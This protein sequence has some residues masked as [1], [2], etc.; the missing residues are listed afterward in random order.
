M[1]FIWSSHEVQIKFEWS[2]TVRISR[3]VREKFIWISREIDMKL[4]WI[5]FEINMNCIRTKVIV[6]SFAIHMKWASRSIVG[7]ALWASTAAETCQTGCIHTVLTEYLEQTKVFPKLILI[8]H[9]PHHAAMHDTITQ[10]IQ[11]VVAKVG[12]DVSL[13]KPH[14]TRAASTSKAAFTNCL[15]GLYFTLPVGALN[16][17]SLVIMKNQ[18]PEITDCLLSNIQWVRV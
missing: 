6:I 15:C 1:K 4:I 8:M 17:H 11:N 5:S 13:F 12:V 18:S 3:S 16:A 2:L 7:F 10:W 14:S 9:S